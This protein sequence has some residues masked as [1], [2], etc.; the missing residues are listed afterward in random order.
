MLTVVAPGTGATLDV[1]VSACSFLAA[2]TR[3]SF[4]ASLVAEFVVG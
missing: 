1:C 3:S 4:L 2:A